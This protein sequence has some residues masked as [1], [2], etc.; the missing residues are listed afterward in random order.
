MRF[1]K[2]GP[3]KLTIYAGFCLEIPNFLTVFPTGSGTVGS[4]PSLFKDRADKSNPSAGQRGF[5]DSPGLL[6][7]GSAKRR[8]LTEFFAA[9]LAEV[10][11]GVQRAAVQHRAQL[12]QGLVR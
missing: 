12:W 3:S 6:D 4:F 7:S 2:L 5:E 11:Q 1:L 10:P 9:S 8:Q